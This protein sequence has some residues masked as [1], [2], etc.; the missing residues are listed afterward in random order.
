MLREE[1]ES[2]VKKCTGGRRGGGGCDRGGTVL[3]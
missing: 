3:E 1:V 2:D